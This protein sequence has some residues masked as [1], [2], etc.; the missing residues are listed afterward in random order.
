MSKYQPYDEWVAGVKMIPLNVNTLVLH[1]SQV[2][3]LTGLKD[4]KAGLAKL[5]DEGHNVVLS[6]RIRT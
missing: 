2:R 3:A 1:P 6:E 4:V 5:R